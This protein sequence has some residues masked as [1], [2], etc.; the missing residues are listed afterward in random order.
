M[1]LGDEKLERWAFVWPRTQATEQANHEESSSDMLP[2][3]YQARKKAISKACIRLV[4]NTVLHEG[5]LYEIP[6]PTNHAS[7]GEEA[8]V[9]ALQELLLF[10]TSP[11]A[12]GLSPSKS[13]P[14][15]TSAHIKHS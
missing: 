13:K 8:V 12:A 3:Q 2:W 6:N 10:F 15:C 9:D 1:S 5:R 4:I 14:D 7:R 11:S